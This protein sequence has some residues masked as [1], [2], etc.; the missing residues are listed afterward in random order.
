MHKGC[1]LLCMLWVL[2]G[3]PL[4][5]GQS[6]TSR[7]PSTP[8]SVTTDTNYF[9]VND[10][11][12]S[13]NKRTRTSIIL[14]ELGMSPGDT[15]RF[16]DL[17]A[18]LDERRK[19]LLNTSLF[20]NTTANVKNWHGKYADVIF[21][22]WER[23]YTFP[24]PIFKLA[25]RNFNQWWVQ[26]GRSLDRINIGVRM[27]QENMT[28]RRDD[29]HADVQFG[30]TQRFALGYNIPYIDKGYKHGVGIL[31]S[32]SRNR[33]VNEST[34]SDNKQQFFRQKEFLRQAYSAG[35]S[36]SYR[37]AI[38]TRHRV[39]LTYNYEKVGDSVVLLNP[40]YLGNGRKEVK[41]LD[42]TYRINYIKAD[43][44]IY[45]L[46]GITVEAEAGKKGI[47]PLSDIDD[48]RLRLNVV[49]YW[50]LARKTY[51]ALGL[52]TQA[53]FGGDQP[54][55]NQRAIGY[56]DD[57]LRGL[58]YYVMDG[59]SFFVFKSTLRQ[60]LLSFKV[61]LPIVPRK[62]S[63][64]PF[65]IL[66]KTYADMGYSYNKMPGLANLNNR[67]LYTGGVGFDIVSFYDTCLRIEYSVN[68]LG[69][70]GLFLHTQLDM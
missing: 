26:E 49:K 6:D 62:F 23:W 2:T 3:I 11:I 42:L 43:S 44:W 51:G 60:E 54:Y 7:L 12:I 36:Y 35:L 37:K 24:I 69:Q 9:I 50:Q 70:K 65:R 8:P 29:L 30:Y 32:Y 28:G 16:V 64:V 14:R 46:K 45:P 40:N 63:T 15:I 53:K 21:E 19:Q 18:T 25:D 33:E 67:F 47:G 59:T 57:Y 56:S 17:A 20:L 61:H 13:G 48:V 22:V 55:V 1:Y 58:E 5:Y 10:I 38:N 34:S 39:F 31:F 4:A 66:A 52:R 41:Y 27:I 68:Q